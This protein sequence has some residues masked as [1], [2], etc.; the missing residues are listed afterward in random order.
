MTRITATLSVLSDKVRPDQITSI[1]SFTPDHTVLKGSDRN[2]PRPVPK[3]F[4]WYV[5]SVQSGEGTVDETL[6]FLLKRLDKLYLGIRN[7][8][9][10]DPSIQI[11]FHVSVTPY[12]DG[13]SLYFREETINGVSRFGGSLDIE[14][15]ET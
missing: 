9:D 11:T 3:A 4:G 7:I 1:L 10:I 6:S 13:V 15:F 2:P 14:F 12:S 8:S 5:T